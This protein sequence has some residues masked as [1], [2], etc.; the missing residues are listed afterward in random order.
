MSLSGQ[1]RREGLAPINDNR[2]ALIGIPVAQL[3]GGRYES[4]SASTRLA[5]LL[6]EWGQQIG[7]LHL[8]HANQMVVRVHRPGDLTGPLRNPRIEVVRAGLTGLVSLD[9]LP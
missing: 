1:L 7:A 4:I 5:T 9:G 8:R 2:Q 6:P 3:T